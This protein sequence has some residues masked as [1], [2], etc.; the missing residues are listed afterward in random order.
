MKKRF[1]LSSISFLLSFSALA[2]VPAPQ[3]PLTGNIG[4]GGIFP[5]LNNGTL[6]FTT[7]ANHTMAYPEQS[8]SFIRV[9]SDVALTATRNLIAPVGIGFQFNVENVTSGGQSIQVIGSTGTGVTI[10]NGAIATVWSDGTNY[11]SLPGF[12]IF[13][14][15]SAISVGAP[16]TPCGPLQNAHQFDITNISL[17]YSCD[18]ALGSWQ[19]HSVGPTL[20]CTAAS[21]YSNT[22]CYGAVADLMP[23]SGF[24][25]AS[26]T[27][28]SAAVNVPA[29]SFTNLDVGKYIRLFPFSGYSV[30]FASDSLTPGNVAKIISVTNSTNVVVNKS[31]L[32]SETEYVQ[33]GTDNVP[34]A[35]AC[36]TANGLFGGSCAWLAGRYGLFTYGQDT[37]GNPVY[38]FAGVK[39]D[40]GDYQNP[41]GGTGA[42]ISCTVGSGQVTSCT[43]TAGGSHY[44]NSNTLMVQFG[45]SGCPSTYAGPCGGALA[46]V[47]TNG[48]GVVVNPVTMIYKG[49]GYGM[50]S[51][52]VP[53]VVATG[54]DGVT[55]T[56]TLSGGTAQTPTIGSGGSGYAISG[57]QEFFAVGGTCTPYITASGTVI[58]GVGTAPTNGSGAVASA[59]WTHAPTGCATPPT[60]LFGD[61]ACWSG[62][63][64]S[65]QCTNLSPMIPAAIPVQVSLVPGV[66][67]LSVGASSL[68]GASLQ[69]PWDGV[70]VDTPTP[71]AMEAQA[72]M[73]GGVFQNEDMGGF[74]ISNSFIGIYATNNA[75][76]GAIH[77]LGLSNAIDVY[78]A[79]ADRGFTL[80]NIQSNGYAPYVNGG[81]WG[82][83]SDDALGDGGFF[84]LD[85]I[86]NIV[87]EPAPYNSVAA[88]IDTWFNVMFW[89][90]ELSA[91]ATDLE[92]TCALG[93]VSPAQRQTG[94]SVSVPQGANSMCYKG[95]TSMGFVNLTR[96][97][98]AAGGHPIT[99]LVGKFLARPDYYGSLGSA[100]LSYVGC[101]GCVPLVSDPWRSESV[102]EGAIE[103]QQANFAIING[104]GYSSG[105][106]LQPIYDMS[107]LVNSGVAGQPQEVAW[108]SISCSSCVNSQAVQ[109]LNIAAVVEN[110]FGEDFRPN[111][112][113]PGQNSEVIFSNYQ[114][115]T[116]TRQG[117]IKANAFNTAGYTF[118][119]A[120]DSIRWLEWTGSTIEMP[121]IAAPSGQTYNVQ[122]DDN[123]VLS[124]AA[125][126]GG[127]TWVSPLAG[128]TVDKIGD[129]RGIVASSCQV[130]ALSEDS[131]TGCT[132]SSHIATCTEAN[133]NAQT[134]NNALLLSTFGGSYTALNGFVATVTGIPGSNQWTADLT[135][136]GV[137]DGSTGAGYESCK[138]ALPQQMRDDPNFAGA[139]INQKSVGGDSAVSEAANYTTNFGSVPAGTIMSAQ[140]GSQDCLNNTAPATIE[141]DLLSVFQQAHALGHI[142]NAETL[143][144]VPSIGGFSPAATSCTYP[145]SIWLSQQGKTAA[146]SDPAIC[147]TNGPGSTSTCGQYWD[148]FTD[149]Q[150]LVPYF[151][152]QAFL[153]PSSGGV[154]C[155]ANHL[156]DMG[157]KRFESAMAVGLISR[158]IPPG[159][160]DTLGIVSYDQTAQLFWNSHVIGVPSP[161]LSMDVTLPNWTTSRTY[162][163]GGREVLNIFGP[164][165][166]ELVWVWNQPVTQCG[167]SQELLPGTPTFISG[168][169]GMSPTTNNTFCVSGSTADAG[170]GECSGGIASNINTA[171][172]SVVNANQTI[173]GTDTIGGALLAKGGS[174]T[175]PASPPAVAAIDK[176]QPTGVYVLPVPGAGTFIAN[177][178][179]IPATLPA[180]AAI[181]VTCYAC[182]GN[183]VTDSVGD[184]FNQIENCSVPAFTNVSQFVALNS[185]GGSGITA[186]GG[187]FGP[188]LV[189]AFTGVVTTSAVDGTPNCGAGSYPIATL[190]TGNTSPSNTGALYT[191]LATSQ[192]GALS[193]ISPSGYLPG[194]YGT[195]SGYNMESAYA[196]YTAGTFSATW[197]TSSIPSGNQAGA[198]IV[199]LKGIS[200]TGDT[201]HLHEFQKSDGTL[202]GGVSGADS[203]SAA[204]GA[205]YALAPAANVVVHDSSSGCWQINV[206]TGGILTS[207]SVTCP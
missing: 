94:H 14:P 44:T 88:A 167:E 5:L 3:V 33:W 72:A 23:A 153:C 39:Q 129:S 151:T 199:A 97:N 189:D 125:S 120:T 56:T 110:G 58:V 24:T 202:L 112:S 32:V 177:G 141:T 164:V 150:D 26:V 170:A 196:P 84:D 108:Q 16:T 155:E 22:A 15:L 140:L 197:I 126:G 38:N 83:R 195:G 73:F 200:Q 171:N 173:G 48:S 30:P 21:V 57:T 130:S 89:G 116:L 6:H 203:A 34:A 179:T 54:G 63:A 35:Q 81:T 50:T 145:V 124:S 201:G 91:H 78:T 51:A 106:I 184:T 147:T 69:G 139:T 71:G 121:T 133:T 162:S 27:M 156:L 134:I 59:A 142:Y 9:V 17:I 41:A 193:F 117:A 29:A 7:D 55:A 192:T 98:R 53:T 136:T 194:T 28:S 92:E 188:A 154:G 172:T 146:N 160:S 138:Y 174:I 103:I 82:H 70:T 148:S 10:P 113:N 191:V 100:E 115:T 198:L 79:S 96:D 52:P 68:A 123:G 45:T 119:G 175:T 95:I 61:S 12:G 204:K 36:A 111:P 65:S 47:A 207:T 64:F 152:N 163:P 13:Q 8:A 182:N 165:N 11:I 101:E 40:T 180:G 18:N 77:D 135:S 43:V 206:S 4:S 109:N 181:L 118:Y 185:V 74:E 157:V 66:S 176:G 46:T 42:T 90:A 183:T 168:C 49:Y 99:N 76:T 20:T 137:P 122:I 67:W 87:T 159:M 25:G 60:I 144:P 80:N 102:Q 2:Q 86:S 190:G 104:V 107:G 166:N 158:T 85:G 187:W 93:G 205:V 1:V 37:F 186:T 131:I 62:S 114:S 149:A 31:A 75:N 169:F 128:K 19:W 178:G 105:T 143:I 127:G 132:V 161:N